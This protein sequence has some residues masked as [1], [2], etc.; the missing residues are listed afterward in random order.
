MEIANRELRRHALMLSDAK[1]ILYSSKKHHI[2]IEAYNDKK[3]I[4]Q[5]EER[6]RDKG[7]L[8]KIQHLQFLETIYEKY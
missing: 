1:R 6:V 8:M 7:K 3:M 5:L 4:Y 2:G